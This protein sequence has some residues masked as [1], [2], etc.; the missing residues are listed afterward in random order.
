VYW[1][2]GVTSE[3]AL[4]NVP[5]IPDSVLPIYYRETAVRWS[6]RPLGADLLAFD[7]VK[8]FA[9]AARVAG[10]FE[11]TAMSA[12]FDATVF[13]GV[14]GRLFT[15]QQNGK[16]IVKEFQLVTYRGGKA[17]AIEP[18]FFCRCPCW[19][20]CPVP[21]PTTTPGSTPAPTRTK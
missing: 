18:A 8:M 14:S 9:Q 6:Q 5:A 19:P 11:P 4:K 20:W 2:G 7:V 17:E 13:Q 16:R 21:G 1:I 10:T 3:S 12:A 15:V